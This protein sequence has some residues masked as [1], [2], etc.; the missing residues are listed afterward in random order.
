MHGVEKSQST[1]Q[2]RAAIT[3]L[4]SA[5]AILSF[6]DRAAEEYGQIRVDLER[7][8]TPIG[9]LDTRIAAH[10]R[11]RGLTLVTNNTREFSMEKSALWR[12]DKIR[13]GSNYNEK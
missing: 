3:L 1:A 12:T 10:A 4:L 7:K 9:P 5:M 8:G 13:N 11:S 6:D 2:N